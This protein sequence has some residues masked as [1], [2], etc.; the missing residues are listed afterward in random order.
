MMDRRQ[1]LVVAPTFLLARPAFAQSRRSSKGV[2][3]Q[4]L[5]LV[6][7]LR[8]EAGRD[9]VIFDPVLERAA[10]EW[11]KEQALR[12]K[13]SHRNFKRR[14]RQA[15]IRSPA[16]ENVAY[17]QD[18]VKAVIRAWHGSRGHRRNMLG[19]YNRMG[20]AVAQNTNSDNRPYWTMIL[21]V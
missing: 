19:I 2:T 13:I 15:G 12:G 20:V 5:P 18:N 14:M 1:F 16:A 21:S 11:S 6:N 3:R 10:L 4:A 9:E 17:G 7:A 8:V